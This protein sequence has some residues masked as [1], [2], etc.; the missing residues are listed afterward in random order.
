MAK[1]QEGHTYQPA[2]L[3]STEDPKQEQRARL[4]KALSRFKPRDANPLQFYNCVR[5]LCIMHNCSIDE[6]LERAALTW[7]GLSM[8]QRELYDS[9]RHAELPIPVPRHLIYRAFQKESE[10]LWSLGRSSAGG[11]QSTRYTLESYKPPPKPSRLKAQ[12]NERRPKY[13]NLLDLPPKVAAMRVPP[14]P[15]RKFSR[16]SPAS[17][18]RIR[19]LTPPAVRRVR[20]IRQI[21]SIASVDIK[22]CARMRILGKGNRTKKTE[23]VEA[24]KLQPDKKLASGISKLPKK[25]T[26]KRKG[27]ASKAKRLAKIKDLQTAQNWD[28][29]IGCVRRRLM[30]HKSL[31]A[32][33]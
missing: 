1:D 21:L 2:A 23:A 11:K 17:G 30:M 19:S 6:G 15:N 7:P 24:G 4:I 22:K 18:R 8:R 13:D 29:A 28:E 32:R 20:S 16:V 31:K 33:S 14:E 3:E 12:L 5:E 26:I 10:G 9:Q 27:V 25:K